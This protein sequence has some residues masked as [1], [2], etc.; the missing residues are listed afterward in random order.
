MSKSKLL[1]LAKQRVVVLDGAMGTSLQQRDLPLSDYRDLENCSEILTFSRP[2]VLRDI[3]R[4][5]LAVGCDA[6]LTN[7]FGANQVVLAEFD[8]VDRVREINTEAARIAGQ[9]CADFAK[10]GR[11][12]FVIGSIGPGTRLPSLQQITWDE[13]LDA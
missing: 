6:V 7:T 4:S 11:P 9:A 3:H 13:L 8:L 1:D 12:R 10:P 2:D 5:F